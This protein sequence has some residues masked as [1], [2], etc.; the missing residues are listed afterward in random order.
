MQTTPSTVTS[1]DGTSIAYDQVGQG[2]AVILVAGALCSRTFWSGP[3]LAQLLAPRF[4]VYNYDRRGRGESGDTQPYAVEREIEDIE[5]L[6]DAAGGSVSLYGH[7]S[8]ASLA[9]EATVRL[10]AKVTKLAM[11]EAPYNDDPAAQR[12]WGDYL[13]HLSEVL[14]AG[15]R[16]D[17][18]VLFMRYT[19]MP[20]GQIEE[21]RQT[22]IWPT[23]EAIAPTLAYDHTAILGEA[24]AVPVEL[25]AR[26]TVP[27]LV[28]YGGASFPFMRDTAQLLDKTIPNAQLRSLDGQTHAVEND[29][30]APVLV[31][32][33]AR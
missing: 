25:A 8:G 29:V 12:A 27:T 16:G 2:P 19:G 33:F 17:A 30:L 22:P 14:A 3:E 23:F 15:R 9:L 1:R 10:G 11:Y 18:V 5:A 7:S 32:F 6:I 20:A 13:Q 24:D 31:E 26:V 21:M 28:M 4:T